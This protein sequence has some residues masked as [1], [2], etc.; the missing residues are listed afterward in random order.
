MVIYLPGN[1]GRGGRTRRSFHFG[2]HSVAK[3]R[4]LGETPPFVI[5]T[6]EMACTLFA[7]CALLDLVTQTN[8]TIYSLFAKNR[9]V[10]PILPKTDPSPD[11]YSYRSATIGSTRIAR[12]AG[13]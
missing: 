4:T 1:P 13:M 11:D 5:N 12:R 3:H 9:G 8:H 10:Y 7:Q 2:K 6:K